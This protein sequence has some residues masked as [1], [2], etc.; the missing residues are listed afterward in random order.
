MYIQVCFSY[1]ENKKINGATFCANNLGLFRAFS[2]DITRFQLDFVMMHF[3][4][5]QAVVQETRAVHKW[6][7]LWLEHV[8]SLIPRASVGICSSASLC[9]STVTPAPGRSQQVFLV[10]KV[11]LSCFKTGFYWYAYVNA[12]PSNLC[13][14]MCKISPLVLPICTRL[15]GLFTLFTLNEISRMEKY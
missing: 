2:V 12:L 3:E 11:W 13:L 9:I 6:F 7:R 1:C 4:D 15:C 8:N 14:Q 5:S 10:Q